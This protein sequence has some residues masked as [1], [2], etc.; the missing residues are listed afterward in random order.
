MFK[1]SDKQLA[2]LFRQGFNKFLD[3]IDRVEILLGVK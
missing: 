2:G 3:K 1:I